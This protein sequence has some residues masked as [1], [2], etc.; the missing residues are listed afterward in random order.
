MGFQTLTSALL[1]RKGF[2]LVMRRLSRYDLGWGRL[3]GCEL[4]RR[5]YLDMRS[6]KEDSRYRAWLVDQGQDVTCHTF[7]ND[8]KQTWVLRPAL[9][10]LLHRRQRNRSVEGKMSA[11]FQMHSSSKP[12]PSPLSGLLFLFCC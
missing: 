6:A 8:A 9:K 4:S 11:V 12:K 3:T 2:G 1:V 7:E 5:R 10:F